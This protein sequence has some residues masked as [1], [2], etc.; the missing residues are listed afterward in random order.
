MGNYRLLTIG[1]GNRL[2]LD[3]GSPLFSSCESS[4]NVASTDSTHSPVH[5]S[6]QVYLKKKT[7][8]FIPNDPKFVVSPDSKDG[9]IILLP[10][11]VNMEFSPAEEEFVKT[12]DDLL[13]DDN[14]LLDPNVKAYCMN[15]KKGNVDYVKKKSAHITLICIL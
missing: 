12:P 9:N 13:V 4:S 10:D 7:I 14:G 6:R 11:P 3:I 2:F 15:N 8:K 1:I 5:A